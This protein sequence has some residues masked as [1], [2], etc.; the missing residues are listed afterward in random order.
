MV[1]KVINIFLFMSLRRKL[2]IIL[3]VFASIPSLLL[4]QQVM[5][6]YKENMIDVASENVHAIISTNNNLIDTTLKGIEDISYLFINNKACYD[7]FS[8]MNHFSTSDYLIQNRLI[9]EEL[10]K[11][12][13]TN[14]I[15]YEKYLYT[16]NWLFGGNNNS[17]SIHATIDEIQKFGIVELADESGGQVRWITGYEYG[18]WFQKEYLKFKKEYDYQYPI[19]MIRQMNFQYTKNGKLNVMPN[20]S[21]KPI[22]ILQILEKTIRDL[23]DETVSYEENLY[24]VVNEKGF[25]ISTNNETFQ[26]A[27]KVPE[28]IIELKKDT[29]FSTYSFNN[30][31]YL[32]C[33]DKIAERG[34]FS[35]CLIPMEALIRHTEGQIHHLQAWMAIIMLIVALIISALLSMT[36]SKP[37][38]TLTKAAQRVSTGDFSANTSIPKGKDFKILTETFNHMETEIT[39]LI[40]ENYE[41]N[42]R[43]K[44]TQIM[45]LSMQINPHFLYNTLNT[46]NMLAIQNNDYETSD[47]IVS[48]SEM[49]HFTF[50]HSEEKI[51]LFDELQWTQNYINIM[52]KRF[53]GIFQTQLKISNILLHYKVPKFFLQPLV[54]NSI[55]HGF[56]EITSGGI[57]LIEAEKQEDNLIF[58]VSDNGRG[59]DYLTSENIKQAVNQNGIG[60]SNVHN[61]LSLIYGENYKVDLYTS[62]GNG[63]IYKLTIPCE[64]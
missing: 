38:D 62:P 22:L 1:K 8:Q 52:A 51:S 36:I 35:F 31:E 49:L 4:Y 18:K 9:S 43:E 29:G 33:Y 57:L 64:S 20:D 26:L 24:V 25:V 23:Y 44:D 39:R 42:L 14:A 15:V 37:I 30:T 46:I 53:A 2:V 60:I 11:Q 21:E 55:L 61:R 54:E 34:W 16:S 12:F 56:Q 17:S 5:N 3:F 47:L 10:G 40:K 7:T 45:A 41:I 63:T 58:T 48:L 13:M 27:A 19:T 32:I 28:D 59:M 6:N 50:K